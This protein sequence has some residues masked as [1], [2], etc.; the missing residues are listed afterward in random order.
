MRSLRLVALSEDGTHLVLAA[1]EP[2]STDDTE[3]FQLPVDDLLLGLLRGET[4]AQPQPAPEPAVPPEVPTARP[5]GAG[6]CGRPA[7]RTASRTAWAWI[8]FGM[9]SAAIARRS[10]T[11]SSGMLET[12]MTGMCAVRGSALRSARSDAPDR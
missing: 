9:T 3:Q 8:G 2:D 1:G 7:D 12:M 10:P 4:A 6:R 11:S 5:G